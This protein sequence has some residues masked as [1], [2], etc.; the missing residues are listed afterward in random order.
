MFL[1]FELVLLSVIFCAKEIMQFPA[2]V[3]SRLALAK[4]GNRQLNV[5]GKT[6][7]NATFECS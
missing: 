6:V 2:S 4:L 1:S 3:T 7:H 5:I